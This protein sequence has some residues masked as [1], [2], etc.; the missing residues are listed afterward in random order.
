LNECLD[1]LDL[2]GELLE[3]VVEEPD[4]RGLVEPVVDPK[5]SDPRAVVDRGELVV[6]LA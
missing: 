3:H 2:E 5:D 4:R 6:L 1:H